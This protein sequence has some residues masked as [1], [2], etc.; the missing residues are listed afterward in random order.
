MELKFKTAERLSHAYII[1][2]PDMKDALSAA[3]EIAAAAVCMRGHDV[4]CGECRACRK[5]LGHIHPDITTIDRLFDDKGQQ[6]REIV[7]DQ[8]RD[9][10]VD[11]YILPNEAE[12]KVYIIKDAD[13]MNV[14][15]QNAALKLFEEPPKGVIFLLC[16]TNP[17]L[18]LQTVRSRCVD[19]KCTG[20]AEQADPEIYKKAMEYM[21]HAAKKNR[22]ELLKWCIENE[23][24]ESR[25][26][27]AMVDCAIDITAD[28][29]TG[30]VKLPGLDR[31]E[32]L[33]ITAL[34]RR[35]SDY[36][37]ANVGTKHIFGILAADTVRT[38]SR[39]Q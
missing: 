18:M 26:A 2:A 38:G 31:A 17:E 22:A 1:S 3:D 36:Y 13:T 11:A 29:L 30:R 28:I 19:I 24:C 34:L 16:V 4:P 20:E 37:K 7:V 23:D 14:Q 12:R 32:L 10:S 9:I 21:K 25:K 15:A 33:H 35:C 39:G 27:A 5:A 6:K 8:V